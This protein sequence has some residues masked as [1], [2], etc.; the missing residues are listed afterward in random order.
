MQAG[1]ISN[2]SG[3]FSVEKIVRGGFSAEMAERERGNP[4]KSVTFAAHLEKHT[5]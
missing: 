2:R 5:L 3:D 4:E 1:R